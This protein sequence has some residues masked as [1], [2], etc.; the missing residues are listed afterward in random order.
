[1]SSNSDFNYFTSLF[2][3]FQPPRNKEKS[4]L[5]F[6]YFE[7]DGS[8]I[9]LLTQDGIKMKP[10]WEIGI[11]IG[12]VRSFVFEIKVIDALWKK[13]KIIGTVNNEVQVIKHVG[14]HSEVVFDGKVSEVVLQDEWDSFA[15]TYRLSCVGTEKYYYDAPVQ[16]QTTWFNMKTTDILKDINVKIQDKTKSRLKGVTTRDNLN[17]VWREGLRLDGQYD[18]LFSTISEMEKAQ[19][20][21][22]PNGEVRFF[23]ESDLK[24][25]Q[26]LRIYNHD[27]KTN[28]TGV[29]GK[30]LR[31]MGM[32]LINDSFV[33]SCF[34]NYNNIKGSLIKGVAK[35]FDN[36]KNK[37][38]GSAS[39]PEQIYDIHKIFINDKDVTKD[40]RFD[41]SIDNDEEN[42][43]NFSGNTLNIK[44]KEKVKSITLWYWKMTSGTAFNQVSGFIIDELKRRELSCSESYVE[45]TTDRINDI[46]DVYSYS[47]NYLHFRNRLQFGMDIEIDDLTIEHDIVS[48]WYDEHKYF[49]KIPVDTQLIHTNGDIVD[50]NLF[51]Y[52]LQHNF[53][54]SKMFFIPHKKTIVQK[55]GTPSGGTVPLENLT[56]QVRLET[57]QHNRMENDWIKE[58]YQKNREDHKTINCN[59]H[60]N[61][62]MIDGNCNVYDGI[63]YTGT[64]LVSQS[65]MANLADAHPQGHVDWE[66][67][68]VEHK[69]KVSDKNSTTN[70][71]G[72]KDGIVWD[73]DALL[74]VKVP[75]LEHVGHVDNSNISYVDVNGDIDA[76]AEKVRMSLY[77][78]NDHKASYQQVVYN[79]HD[80]KYYYFMYMFMSSPVSELVVRH[81]EVLETVTK[82]V[83]IP[84]ALHV[85]DKTTGKN[86]TT[87]DNS[88]FALFFIRTG[89]N[90]IIT[91]FYL[92]PFTLSAQSVPTVAGHE[93]L[94]KFN[95]GQ[96]EDKFI[97]DRVRGA[98]NGKVRSWFSWEKG[99]PANMIAGNKCWNDWDEQ[100][101]D[102]KV[103]HIKDQFLHFYGD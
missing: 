81:K 24:E 15:R 33:N 55:I 45:L 99:S 77:K 73:G 37:F 8:K 10:N 13:E 102:D 97:I 79:I 26:E 16:G 56:M 6:I 29:L 19:Y 32:E 47:E 95:V 2:N 38:T 54:G 11:E 51:L 96:F 14:S 42:V 87:F 18:R 68:K 9:N 30:S 63:K 92:D 59:L 4:Y 41:N 23:V 60:I 43:Y 64:D 1:M 80:N 100:W 94:F 53:D 90:K 35:N 89:G 93:D 44:T 76:I 36:D 98:G 72:C 3:R 31:V 22:R 82:T 83:K 85:V 46:H 61:W 25:G 20:M 67:R 65:E 49:W 86:A 52:D 78:D 34:M 28:I 58:R 69:E 5:E 39:F 21:F 103:F 50:T 91:D 88:R 84:T 101:T 12:Q 17:Y 62:D 71:A 27:D 74:E 57:D 7:N 75:N 40:Y 48:N 70:F 66:Y